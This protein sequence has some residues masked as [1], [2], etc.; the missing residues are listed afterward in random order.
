[1]YTNSRREAHNVGCYLIILGGKRTLA[2]GETA[3]VTS[4]WQ[5]GLQL[6]TFT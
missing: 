2:L 3:F 6:E 4:E 1:M 5:Q